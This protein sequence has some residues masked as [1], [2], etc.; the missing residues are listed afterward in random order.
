VAV[1]IFSLLLFLERNIQESLLLSFISSSLV[2]SIV[3]IKNNTGNKRM[4]VYS[5]STNQK[6]RYL[7]FVVIFIV[8]IIAHY[9]LLCN[10][11]NFC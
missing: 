11:L 5:E 7:A 3:Q 1:I 8:W 10:K 9:F 6:L 2:E 4:Y